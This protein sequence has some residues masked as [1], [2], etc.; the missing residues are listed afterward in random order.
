MLYHQELVNAL[1]AVGYSKAPPS[2]LDV[3][4]EL[5]KHGAFRIAL[6]ICFYPVMFYG[7]KYLMEPDTQ[8]SREFKKNLYSTSPLKEILQ[9]EM[10]VWAAKGWW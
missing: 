8:S 7:W 10:S 3:N 6:W 5:L 2:L 4:L 1:K 9:K